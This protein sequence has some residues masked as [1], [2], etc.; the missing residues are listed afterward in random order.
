[1]T[2]G[3]IQLGNEMIQLFNQ[4][5]KVKEAFLRGS[6]AK[7]EFDEYSDIDIGIDVS[8][9]DNGAF[10]LE[11]PEILAKHFPILF[12]DWAPSLLPDS[13]VQTYFLSGNPPFWFIDI[14]CIATPHAPSVT[15]VKNDFVGHHLK[16]WIL[17]SKYY[18]RGNPNTNEQIK[19]LAHKVLHHDVWSTS[20]SELLK[21]Y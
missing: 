18:L 11:L 20:P 3:R 14:E 15:H 7:G 2:D 13:Y 1:M 19:N 9:Y 16:L 5:D 8:G 17:L 21:I 12:Y 6:L 4:E 10:A